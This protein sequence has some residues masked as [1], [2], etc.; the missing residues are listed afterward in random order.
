MRKFP[1]S[2]IFA[3]FNKQKAEFEKAMITKDIT[4]TKLADINQTISAIKIEIEDGKKVE[5]LFQEVAK[6]TQL[7]IEEHISNLVTLALKSVSPDFPN[8]VTKF[9]IRRK[10]LEAD[11]LFEKEGHLFDPM[12]GDG[13]GPKD[14]GS[15]G[16]IIANWS[17]DKTR[18][19]II[20]DEPFKQ[21][22]PDLQ[23]N[24]SNM[25]KMLHKELEIQFIIVS[26]ADDINM[27]ADKTFVVEMKDGTSTV[28]EV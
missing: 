21:V 18:A 22:S 7:N 5:I 11:L 8:F 2:D 26:H 27:A 6:Q 19:T 12:Y 15:F 9:T 14:T 16:L 20:L 17:I 1:M 24:V 23:E 4:E 10:Q 25:I 13:G 28:K 3:L